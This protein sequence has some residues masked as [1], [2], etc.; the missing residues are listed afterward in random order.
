ML[1]ETISINHLALRNRIVMPPMATGKA[2][3]GMPDDSLIAYYALRAE[4][5]ALIIL[6]HE[7]ISP[8]GMARETQL[9][10]ADDAVIPAFKKLTGA[11]H[12]RGAAIFAQINHAGAA[13]RGSGLPSISP[14][15]VSLRD[16]AP[17]SA[18]MT[19]DDIY[20]VTECFAT[21]AVRA[22]TA[23]F[24]GVEIHSAHGYLLNQFYSPLTNHRTDE[25]DGQSLEGR[26]RFHREILQAVRAAVG[27]DYPIAIRFGA[28]DYMKGGS[29]KD[30]I[31]AACRIF[32]EAGADLLDISGGLNGFTIEG[33]TRPGWF[34]E[35]SRSAKESVQIPVLLTGGITTAQ[36]AERLLQEGAADLI[37]IGRAMLETPDWSVR[38]IASI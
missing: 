1:K 37:G 14:S 28:C 24:D 16:D 18:S 26:I 9:S 5:T 36:D 30:D 27:S 17:A 20:R 4:A 29:V 8:E 22:R 7:Y 34:S 31:P 23:G 6:E 25:Y 11:I 15:G 32:E 33:E 3:H 21:A 19:K 2:V 10:M 13:A 38:A 12:E 35:L